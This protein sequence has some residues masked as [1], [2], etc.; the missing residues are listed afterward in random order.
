MHI[1]LRL[2]PLSANQRM[3][4][5]DKLFGKRLKIKNRNPHQEEERGRFMPPPETPTDDKFILNFKEN[6]GKFLYCSNR[7]DVQTTFAEILKENNWNDQAC[8][9]DKGLALMFN[10]F[11]LNFSTDIEAPFCLLT[12][13]FLVAD[14]GGILLSSNQIGEDKISELP[15]GLVVFAG[16]S[17]LIETLSDGLRI[18]NTRRQDLPTNIRT[19]KNFSQDPE[20]DNH[21][22]N[23]GS[24]SKNVYLLLLEDL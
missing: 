15:Y 16:T 14:T 9:Y 10:D 22:M 18:I 1:A 12:C 24:T 23:Y 7:E 20:Q 19:I 3:H 21:F 13:E 2:N 4:L 8:C 11:N 5:F 6:G 17:Q